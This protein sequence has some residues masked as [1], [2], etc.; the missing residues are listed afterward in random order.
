MKGLNM[1]TSKTKKE[2]L[3]E[4]FEHGKDISKHFDIDTGVKTVNVDLPIWAIKS[5]DLEATRR[6]VARQA[7]IKMWLIDRVDELEKKAIG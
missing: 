4:D 1:K 5:L 7:L 2:Q 3:V 6:G